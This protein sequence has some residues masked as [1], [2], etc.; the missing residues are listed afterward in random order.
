MQLIRRRLRSEA[1]YTLIELLAGM[2][3]SMVVLLAAFELLDSSVTL[4]HRT[5]Q[6]VGATQRGRQAM[7]TMTRALR[8]QVCLDKTEP[9]AEGKWNG[10]V[11][12]VTFYADF[13]DG[14]GTTPPQKRVLAYDRAAGTIT[15]SV[16]AGTVSG[17]TVTYTTPP[18]VTT[19]LDDVAPNP[20]VP[21][22]ASGNR[23]VF[24]FYK[25]DTA[26]KPA[27]IGPLALPLSATDKAAVTKIAIAFGV[28]RENGPAS[29]D[30]MSVQSDEVFV[31]AADPNITNPTPTCA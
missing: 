22:D 23:P 31:R 17:S 3:I 26:P 8:S 10:T 9:I 27:W 16:Y 20:D 28:R 24:R 5:E 21:V 18:R 11:Q 15:E 6:R 12:S 1:G 4:T 2:A 19:L 7:D 13:S 29:E 14:S 30:P 25:F